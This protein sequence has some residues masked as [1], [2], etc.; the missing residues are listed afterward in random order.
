[1]KWQI[2]IVTKPADNDVSQPNNIQTQRYTGLR[3]QLYAWILRW[4]GREVDM[5]SRDRGLKSRLNTGAKV[6]KV[7]VNVDLYSASS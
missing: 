4:H 1:M 6:G 2:R 7:K 5:S 3:I